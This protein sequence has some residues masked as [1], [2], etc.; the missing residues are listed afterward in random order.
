MIEIKKNKKN[1]IEIYLFKE[2]FLKVK[3]LKVLKSHAK[4]I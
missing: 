2:I 3:N 4:I 1:K